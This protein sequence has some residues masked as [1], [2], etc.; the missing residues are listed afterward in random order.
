MA[1]KRSSLFFLFWLG[2]ILPCNAMA[3]SSV[4]TASPQNPAAVSSPEKLQSKLD[5]LSAW[6]GDWHCEGKFAKSHITI[7]STISFTPALK[8][9]WIEMHQD[10]IH[11]DRFHALE[12]WGY[13]E[14]RSLFTAAIFDNANAQP[15]QFTADGLHDGKLTLSRDVADGSP[16][17][18]EQFVFENSGDKLTVTYQGMV[19]RGDKWRM[20]DVLTCTR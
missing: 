5:L 3:Q 17:K 14:K 20:G 19:G 15:R 8:G 1:S 9:R 18:T 11:P 7:T 6:M 10:D 12:M 13:D 4:S 2:L 16:L